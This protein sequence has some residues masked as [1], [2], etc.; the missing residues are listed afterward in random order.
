MCLTSPLCRGWTSAAL[1]SAGLLFRDTYLFADLA[2][3][4]MPVPY[5]EDQVPTVLVCSVWRSQ[6]TVPACCHESP[7]EILHV[8]MDPLI[9]LES[10]NITECGLET[11]DG[12]EGLTG[13]TALHLSSNHLQS[14]DGVR[15]MTRLRKL[16]AN[17]NRIKTVSI[18]KG[19]T[20]H[21]V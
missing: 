4:M 6:T 9:G 14:L 3:V 10:L 18:G 11:T 7:I 13:L 21:Q 2:L 19:V 8:A 5:I 17:D 15:G 16:W 1:V 12:L 20:I